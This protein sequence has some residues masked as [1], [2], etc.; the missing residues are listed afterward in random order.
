MEFLVRNHHGRACAA[1][2]TTI[3]RLK[4][5][6]NS[7]LKE[8]D[9]CRMVH[10]ISSLHCIDNRDVSEAFLSISLFPRKTR[11]KPR[12]NIMPSAADAK[13]SHIRLTSVRELRIIRGILTALYSGQIRVD[14]PSGSLRPGSEL[15]GMRG[16]GGDRVEGVQPSGES[17]RMI[18]HR[19]RRVGCGHFQAY[20]CYGES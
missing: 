15:H 13:S 3:A 10:S 2:L 18:W 8:R 11:P 6:E 17:G 20:C 7:E 9:S 1:I 14:A 4:M 16:R 12:T 5:R 19:C